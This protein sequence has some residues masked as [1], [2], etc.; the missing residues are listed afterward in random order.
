IA[1][2][3]YNG[4][5]ITGSFEQNLLKNSVDLVIPNNQYLDEIQAASPNTPQ[6]IYSNVSNLY[7]GLL[8]DWLSYAD[9]TNASRELAFYHV[10]KATPFSGTSSSAQPVKW[11]WGAFQTTSGGTPIDVTS[12]A[13]AGRNFNVQFGAAGTTTAMGYIEKFREM[14][15]TLAR[16]AVS[17]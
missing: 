9:R 12:A 8:S 2:L 3:A 13:R 1:Q 16:A 15:I 10:T 7:Q 17:G 11:F 5:P 14:N 4:T 6:L